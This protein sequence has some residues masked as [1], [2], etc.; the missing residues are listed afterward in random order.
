MCRMKALSPPLRFDRAFF[1]LALDTLAVG[2]GLALPWSTSVT[3]IFV[4]LWVITALLRIDFTALKQE[5][6]TAAGGSPVLLWCLG[7]LG[8]LWADVS[9]AER[10]GGVGGFSRLLVIPF[11]LQ[12][13][14]CS[15]R[16]DWVIFG[17]LFSSAVVLL[18]SFVLVLPPGLSWRGHV[19]ACRCTMTYFKA[20]AL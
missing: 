5:L 4:A 1:E 15:R 8:M 14:R 17:L 9:W 13:F 6:V 18:L 2:V 3:G 7:T 16:G 20:S 19:P 12:H 10:F 11:L